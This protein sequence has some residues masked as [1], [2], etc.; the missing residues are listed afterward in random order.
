MGAN[1]NIL[2]KIGYFEIFAEKQPTNKIHLLIKSVSPA[3]IKKQKKSS[4]FS[5]LLTQTLV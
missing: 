4:F 2:S 5:S 3:T 1:K